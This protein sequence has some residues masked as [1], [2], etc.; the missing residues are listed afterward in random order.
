MLKI[1]KINLIIKY[2]EKINFELILYI[3]YKFYNIAMSAPS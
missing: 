3:H 2:F 1:G